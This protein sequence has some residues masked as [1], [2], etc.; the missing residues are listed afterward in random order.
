MSIYD[1]PTQL[2]CQNRIL[3]VKFDFATQFEFQNTTLNVE[4]AFSYSVRMSK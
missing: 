4:I 3:N 1:F 2:E